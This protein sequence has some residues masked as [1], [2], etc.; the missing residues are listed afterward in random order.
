[1]FHVVNLVGRELVARC[2]C[3]AR[4]TTNAEFVR[5]VQER[6]DAK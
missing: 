3:G 6:L 4:W 5:S 1:M 2:E